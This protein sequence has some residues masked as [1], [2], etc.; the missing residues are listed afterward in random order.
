M[1]AWS[2]NLGFAA[3]EASASGD[4]VVEV[5]ARPGIVVGA[6]ER[7]REAAARATVKPGSGGRTVAVPG[8]NR[9]N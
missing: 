7:G 3:G 6:V 2:L 8:G 4:R 9:T 1:L 5:A